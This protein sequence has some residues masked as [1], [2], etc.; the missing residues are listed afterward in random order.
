MPWLGFITREAARALRQARPVRL[1]DISRIGQES[2]LS[3][4][5]I[6]LPDERYVHGCLT[7]DGAYAVFEA[8]IATVAA[9]A[10]TSPTP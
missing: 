6:D 5:W 1:V 2:A 8:S 3:V 4:S 7:P 9:P 10:S